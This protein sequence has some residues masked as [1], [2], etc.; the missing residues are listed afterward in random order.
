MMELKKSFSKM[1]MRHLDFLRRFPLK[2]TGWKN[3]ILIL[4]EAAKTPNKPKPT[5][6]TQLS[7]TERPVKS[8]QPS[9]S[10]TQD[11]DKGVL[12]GCESTSVRTGDLLTV[13]SQCLLNF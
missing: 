8:E 1:Y 3:W 7:R 2:T 12:F 13:V 5:S 4:L 11:I 6:K 10:S 9:G